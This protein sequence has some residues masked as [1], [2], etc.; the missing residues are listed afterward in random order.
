[1][2]ISRPVLAHYRD[3]IF[4]KMGRDRVPPNFEPRDDEPDGFS[5]VDGCRARGKNILE[6]SL[7][8]EP[9]HAGE[10]A[11]VADVRVG[12]GLCNPAMYVAADLLADFAR[13]QAAGA[14]LALDP[15]AP[16]TLDPLFAALA[17]EDEAARPE[18]A[19]EKFQYGLIA[20][21]NAVRSALGRAP[22][23]VPE[24]AEPGAWEHAE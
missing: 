23:E 17:P 14:L 20:L 9:G 3:R 21:Q 12:C 5:T 10:D 6:L 4:A 22:L 16:A 18:D 15:L 1:M 19:R 11:R 2:P 24:V 7:W 8:F 13:G